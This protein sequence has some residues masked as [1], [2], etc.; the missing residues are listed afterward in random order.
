MKKVVTLLG[1]GLVLSSLMLT[2]CED[3][4]NDKPVVPNQNVND[5][6]Y[7]S[8]KALKKDKIK[9][10]NQLKMNDQQ[11][12]E[13]DS[14]IKQLPKDKQTLVNDMYA[15][16]NKYYFAKN[17]DQSMNT[18]SDYVVFVKDSDKFNELYKD[19]LQ[20]FAKSHSKKQ[21]TIYTA[22][23]QSL[24]MGDKNIKVKSSDD[25]KKDF[26]NDNF[27]VDEVPSFF[28]VKDGKIK[29]NFVG[30]YDKANLNN[31]VSKVERGS[32]DGK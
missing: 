6:D 7:N 17:Y 11:K 30:Y 5:M 21:L 22:S 15:E 8:Q 12:Q 1:S 9:T 27:V 3:E 28:V 19:V 23:G 25:A 10:S 29:G 31:Y 26:G 4:S 14:L 2:G 13:F 16:T 32:K 24:S 18:K 20:D